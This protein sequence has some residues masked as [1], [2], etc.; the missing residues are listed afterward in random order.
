ME[1]FRDREVAAELTVL[2]GMRV[3]A[4]KEAAWFEVKVRPVAWYYRTWLRVLVRYTPKE[5][6]GLVDE[7]F[8][9]LLITTGVETNAPAAIEADDSAEN[10]I[11]LVAELYVQDIADE[12]TW[13]LTWLADT[14]ISAGTTTSN[15][16][17]AGR[18]LTL[19]MAI[20]NE[21]G[22]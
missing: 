19:V 14:P 1:N 13:Q 17:L 5:E 7:G 12:P 22:K 10:V 9:R 11:F 21:A 6:V 15:P 20:V 16:V 4:K 2:L 3:R 18:A 8:M